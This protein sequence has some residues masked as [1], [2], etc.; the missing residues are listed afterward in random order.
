[1]KATSHLP[2]YLIEGGA[3]GTFMVSA[4]TLSW[5]LEATNSPIHGIIESGDIRRALIGIAMGLTS[6]SLV[7][8]PWGRRSGAHMNPALTLTFWTLGKVARRDAVFYALA[9]FI[10]GTLG[11]LVVAGIIGAGVVE[12]PVSYAQTVPG[13]HGA[14]VA[15]VCEVIIAFIMMLTILTF[16]NRQRL[17]P[18]TG[19]ACAVLVATYITFEAPLSGMSL[20]PAR[21]FASAAPAQHWQHLWIYFLAPPLGMLA[22]AFVYRRLPNAQVLC[23]KIFHALDQRCIHC[24]YE[25]AAQ[26]EASYARQ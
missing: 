16:S 8:S 12:P 17:M 11:V 23:A 4:G 7:Y 13:P 18:Y 22:A 6:M 25:P 21:S 20:N 19:I 5:L 1:M 15:F 9:Q 24:G 10:G 2:E 14:G 26:Q 3:L